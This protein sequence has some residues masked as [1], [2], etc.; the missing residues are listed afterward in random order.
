VF[1]RLLV[2]IGVVIGGGA[3]WG[4]LE[5]YVIPL[6]ERPFSPLH[7]LYAPT[8]LIGQG[9]GVVGTLMILSGVSLYALRKRVR[10][11][12]RVGKL[13]DWLHFHIFLCLLGPFLVLLHTTFKF[14]GVV[15]I[16]FWSMTLVVASGVFGRWVY[17]W[18][19]KTMN[20]RFL[21]AEE[22]RAQMGT[23]LAQ[24]EDQV[25]LTAEELAGI[26]RPAQRATAGAGPGA[27]ERSAGDRRR[28]GREG[29]E[30]RRSDRPLGILGALAVSVRHRFG[31]RKE[32]AR[33]HRELAAVGVAE[34]VRARIIGRL[35]EERRLEQQLRVLDPFRRA[36]RYWHAF[37]LPLAVVM[38]LVLIVHV[39]VAVAFGYTW[40]FAAS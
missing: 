21:G 4:G 20:G 18:I 13:R 6:Q 37:H 27:S 25:S 24:L 2:L 14:G 8:G 29:Q 30:R 33:L 35:E 39:G 17:V 28:P 32:R 36:F 12:A 3:L 9:L 34:T 40:I 11:F 22:L 26:L 31:R 5:Y 38:L 10:M 16:S 7:D 19:P 15:A 23:L 1:V